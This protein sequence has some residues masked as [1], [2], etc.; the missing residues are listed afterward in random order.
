MR[1]SQFNY[2][3]NND[4]FF[5]VAFIIKKVWLVIFEM[6][7]NPYRNRTCIRLREV[8]WRRHGIS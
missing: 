5:C 3:E 8:G 6:V 2:A 1:H 4:I 7:F